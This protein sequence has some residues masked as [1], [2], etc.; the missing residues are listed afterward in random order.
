MSYGQTLLRQYL[1]AIVG[2]DYFENYRPAWLNG[3]ELDFFYPEFNLAVEFNGD[4]HYVPTSMG[5]PKAQRFRDAKKRQICRNHGV[6][7]LV[8]T[9]ADLLNSRMRMK[10]K[11]TKTCNLLACVKMPALDTASKQYR[12]TLVKSFNGPTARRKKS[13]PWREA[14]AAAW[15]KHE[16]SDSAK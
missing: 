12:A 10:V 8:I 2:H 13:K 14:T 6:K 9:A 15:A 7:L 5:C 16:R 4:Q 11:N 1:E 3:M